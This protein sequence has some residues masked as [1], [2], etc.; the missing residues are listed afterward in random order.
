[1]LDIGEV[2]RRSGINASALR[3]YEQKGL[4]HSCA[5]YGLRRQYTEQVLQQLQLIMLAQFAGFSLDEIG[6]CFTSDREI[7]LDR[8]LLQRKQTQ[9]QHAMA[10]LQ[11]VQQ[12]LQHMIDCPHNKHIDCPSFQALLQDAMAMEQRHQTTE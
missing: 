3:Y 2:V 9:V 5:R 11:Y 4:I 10:K 12:M 1:M 6:Q 7:T 8:S